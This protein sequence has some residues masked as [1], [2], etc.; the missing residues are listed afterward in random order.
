MAVFTDA[1]RVYL[2][3]QRL[4]RLATASE[5]G[6]P[7]VSAVGFSVDGETIVSGGLDLTRTVRYRHLR[8][9]PRAT[10]VV[11]DV[12]SMDPWQPR[13]IK[14]RGRAVLED[15]GGKPRIR[16]HPVTVWSWGINEGAP[17]HFAGRIEKREVD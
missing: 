1:E 12:A 4:A 6:Q 16:I 3:G 2:S 13:G 10:L 15:D 7:D 9:N 17:K 11:D 14:V 8:R 5:D